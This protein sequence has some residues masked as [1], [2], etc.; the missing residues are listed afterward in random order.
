[1]LKQ[2]G[3][4]VHRV[5]RLTINR[6]SRCSNLIDSHFSLQSSHRCMGCWVHVHAHCYQMWKLVGYDTRRVAQSIEM[7]ML[8]G[9]RWRTGWNQKQRQDA[10][11]K[12]VMLDA[13]PSNNSSGFL[14]AWYPS[15]NRKE[16]FFNVKNVFRF[17]SPQKLRWITF[18]LI[19]QSRAYRYV[20]FWTRSSIVD[21]FNLSTI[22]VSR[23]QIWQTGNRRT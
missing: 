7:K 11:F 4:T 1:M 21:L 2:R 22:L 13:G 17:K 5:T 10:G 8:I 19:P 15:V 9:A 14:I 16:L 12:K 3:L 20:F 23:L 6:Q 18:S